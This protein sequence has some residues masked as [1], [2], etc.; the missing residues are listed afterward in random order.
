[1]KQKVANH[2]ELEKKF[3]TAVTDA[4]KI[5]ET[6]NS[7]LKVFEQQRIEK[8]KEENTPKGKLKSIKRKLPEVITTLGAIKKEA[9]SND[10]LESYADD[11]LECAGELS[12]AL[13]AALKVEEKAMNIVD[14]RKKATALTS[15][16]RNIG[17]YADRAKN[18]EKAKA[19]QKSA[20]GYTEEFKHTLDMLRV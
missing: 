4:S 17:L 13:D 16:T 6:L 14:L 11:A 10:L 12:K 7:S 20:Y 1:M 3:G 18:P 9:K 8:E 5:T 19:L 2:K 15:M